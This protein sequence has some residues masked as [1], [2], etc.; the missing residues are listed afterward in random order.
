MHPLVQT[1]LTGNIAS[2]F[3]HR[4]LVPHMSN[5]VKKNNNN[6]SLTPILYTISAP[7]LKRSGFIAW[8]AEK[9]TSQAKE[10]SMLSSIA[11]LIKIKVK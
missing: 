10:I 6:L 9:I 1:I 7:I 11:E 4:A 3:F 8:F 2:D 5:L